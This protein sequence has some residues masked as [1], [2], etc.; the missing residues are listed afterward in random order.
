MF[1][2][3]KLIQF[4]VAIVGFLFLL[5]GGWFLSRVSF[6]AWAV[7]RLPRLERKLEQEEGVQ[8]RKVL[9]KKSASGALYMRA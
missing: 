5:N 8:K 7:V 2:E 9:T 1:I 3:D 4:L 6:I